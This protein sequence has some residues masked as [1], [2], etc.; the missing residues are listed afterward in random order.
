[1]TSKQ[2]VTFSSITE[3]FLFFRPEINWQPKVRKCHVIK[4]AFYALLTIK[5]LQLLSFKNGDIARHI[6][7]GNFC[8]GLA[9]Q[10][11][12]LI[13]PTVILFVEFFILLSYQI[14]LFRKRP[15]RVV[16][17][18]KIVGK[19]FLCL[20]DPQQ[21]QLV[22]GAQFFMI[23]S[24]A[25]CVSVCVYG[26]HH[27]IANYDVTLFEKVQLLFWAIA[28]AYFGWN[29]NATCF[30]VAFCVRL[31]CLHV[32]QQ[33]TRWSLDTS[34]TTAQKLQ[35]FDKLCTLVH[36]LN[37]YWRDFN[38]LFVVATAIVS[39]TYLSV[40]VLY[41]ALPMVIAIGYVGIMFAFC[42]TCTLVVLFSAILHTH[43]AKCYKQ[44]LQMYN[45]E[46]FVREYIKLNYVLRKFEQ[47]RV[48]TLSEAI[49]M[50]FDGCR[51][52]ILQNCDRTVMRLLTISIFRS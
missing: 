2:L 14:F 7:H 44:L 40:V 15:Q 33:I 23:S 21:R 10:P 20:G 31:C 35:E 18:A 8:I 37:L 28:F 13:G 32:A 49:P 43:I 29:A 47:L 46:R 38:Y 51:E 16:F 26:A 22:R 39:S 12:L 4:T 17:V 45:A 52:V 42:L 30:A 1:M 5:L 24:L 6:R 19:Y 25:A 50:T 48:F 11:D 34:M 41:D 9:K 3:Q 36:E 27:T